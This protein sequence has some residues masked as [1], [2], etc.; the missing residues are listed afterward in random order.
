MAA[1]WL[2]APRHDVT[3]YERAGRLGGHSNTVEAATSAGVIPVDTGF[4]VYNEA[5]YPNL[6]ALFAH[7]GVETKPSDM[8]FGVSIRGGALEY[9][10]GDL[11]GLNGLLA[12]RRNI[13]RPRFWAMV[14]DLLRFYRE[15]PKEVAALPPE[16]TLGE[17][18]CERRYSRAFQDDHLLPLGGAIWSMTPQAMLDYPAAAFIRFHDNHGLLRLRDRPVWRT[19]VGGSKAY[20]EKLTALYRDEVRLSCGARRIRRDGEGVLLT[21]ERGETRR[22]DHVVIAAHADQ[23]L[24]MLDDPDAQ[25]QQLLG[26]CHYTRNL[27]VLHQ[28]KTL[29]PR[30][31]AA[32]SSWNYISEA[33]DSARG[34]GCVTYWMNRL[35]GI[36]EAVP[37]FV[38]INPPRPPRAGTI[39]F[40]E[41]Y[42]HPL[43]DNGALTAQR[44]LWSLQ[45]R[46]NS[47]FCGAY[48]G[49]GFHEDGLQAGLA[50]A[51]ALGNVRRPWAVANESG[52]ITIQSV[53]AVSAATE[54]VG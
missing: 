22:F 33:D 17:Y 53:G 13:V 31:R 15:A 18:L 50:V 47:W 23:A 30:R 11:G 46:R 29:M 49:S 38:T 14:R 6:T 21:D 42:E 41:I 34:D 5:T 4:I 19:V 37:L 36:D 39:L 8:S 45:G 10:G 12:Q 43:F 7:L 32:W 25:E 27:V 35:Q 2:L 40:S 48:F 16:T 28:D 20:V 1:A 52:R 51:E 3:V 24:A 26:A 44:N 54:S 9:S